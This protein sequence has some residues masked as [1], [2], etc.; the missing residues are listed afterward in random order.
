MPATG[1]TNSHLAVPI[2]RLERRYKHRPSHINYLISDC[3]KEAN[4]SSSR[5]SSQWFSVTRADE[6]FLTCLVRQC[7]IR[8]TPDLHCKNVAR[9]WEIP[10]RFIPCHDL[11]PFSAVSA[12]SAR[13]PAGNPLSVGVIH[14]ACL[15]HKCRLPVFG[16]SR[17][18]VRILT[19]VQRRLVY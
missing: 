19:R 1:D 6:V 2:V 18:C 13:C 17:A 12:M 9:L 3:G 4:P 8:E 5:I 11:P 16:R 10:T 14:S 15:Y 7:A